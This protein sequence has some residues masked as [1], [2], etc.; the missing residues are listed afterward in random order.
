MI[1]FI[2]FIDKLI[3]PIVIPQ[4]QDNYTRKVLYGIGDGVCV[5]GGRVKAITRTAF[6]VK[7]TKRD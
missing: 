4:K 2:N 5:G 6:A 7:N 1:K 3:N